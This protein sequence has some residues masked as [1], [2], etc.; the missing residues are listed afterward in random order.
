MHQVNAGYTLLAPIAA[1]REGELRTLLRGYAETATQP[2]R[3]GFEAC[4][5]THFASIT[6]IDEHVRDDEILPAT[7]LFATSFAGPLRDHLRELVATTGP[8]LR[9]I[10]GACDPY[11]RDCADADLEAYLLEHR[12]ADT[13]YSGMQHLTR[14]DVRRNQQLHAAIAGFLDGPAAPRGTPAEVRAAI[15]RFVGEDPE[16]AWAL[17]P[18]VLPPGATWAL[19]KRGILLIGGAASYVVGLLVA[20]IAGLAG[21]ATLGWIALAGWAAVVGFVAFLA[22]VLGGVIVADRRQDYTSGRQDDARVRE[23]SAAQNRPVINEV[24]I[25]GPIK[26]GATRP[27]YM[28]LA[29][30]IIARA[31][32]GVPVPGYWDGIDIPTVAT[33]RWIAGDRGRRLIFISNY[34]NAAEPYVR[35]FIDK[36]D[37]PRNINLSFGFGRGYPQLHRLVQGGADQ[38]PNEFIYVVT[39]HQQLTDYW[40]GPYKDLSIDNIKRD[41]AIRKGL[42]DPPPKDGIQAWLHLL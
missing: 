38:H 11:L 37:G 8:Q 23:L 34:T 9:A 12:H 28:R 31:A 25:T 19:K 3:F 16:L 7:L 36:D 10:L 5:S 30:W 18:W 14:A 39:E 17:E 29:F 40:F 35:D 41:F 4:A 6:V 2:D 21:C 22:V 13:F 27:L 24:T 42:A 1:G 33:A 20:S 15:R 32:E 26:D